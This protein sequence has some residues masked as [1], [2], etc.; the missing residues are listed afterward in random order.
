[1]NRQ[2]DSGVFQSLEKPVRYISNHWNFA[3]PVFCVLILFAIR[4]TGPSNLLDNEQERPASYVMDILLNG[5][6]LCQFDYNGDVMSKP[7]LFSWIAAAASMWTTPGEAAL[8][9][10]CLV[11]SLIIVIGMMR[12]GVW[13]GNPLVGV[14]A[15]MTWLFSPFGFKHLALARTDALFAALVFVSSLLVYRAMREGRGW[16][17]AWLV[18][19]LAVLTKGPLAVPLALFGLLAFVVRGTPPVVNVP[20]RHIVVGVGLML[21][22]AAGW[23]LIAYLEVGRPLVDTMIFRELVGHAVKETDGRFGEGFIKAPLY[24]FSRTFPWSLPAVAGLFL[25]LRRPRSAETP[26][27]LSFLCWSVLG[28]LAV[29]SLGTHQ[30]SDLVL[31]LVPAFLL[32][33]GWLLVRWMGHGLGPI[34]MTVAALVLLAGFAVYDRTVFAADQVVAESTRTR[35]LA[36]AARNKLPAGVDVYPV[37]TRYALLFHLRRLQ[38]P[39]S[40]P[41]AAARLR[42]EEPVVITVSN[43]RQLYRRLGGRMD[44]IHILAAGPVADD[45]MIYIVSNQPPDS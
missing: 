36:T 5:N 27:L 26:R 14:V 17:S 39:I 38:K 4:V 43:A 25:V 29:L 35:A 3:L 41:E 22:I 16:I 7:P 44:G 37:D 42:G 13:L 45:R 33:G 34:K 23:F 20:W 28:G 24:L 12:A 8:Y 32:V 40:F 11:A 31:P 1:M 21:G 18:I 9:A 2:A 10:P 6:W 15:S 19:T 30:R